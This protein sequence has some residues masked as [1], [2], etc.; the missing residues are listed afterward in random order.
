MGICAAL[1]LAACAEEEGRL[2]PQS[3]DRPWP[4]PS[5]SEVAARGGADQA[6]SI[7][8]HSLAPRA[9][10]EPEERAVDPTH[11]YGLADL[12]DLAQR[13]NPQTREAWE[14]ARAAAAQVGLAESEYLPQLSAEAI[15]GYQRTPLPIPATLVPQGYFTSDT[16]EVVP[17]LAVKWLLFDFGRRHAADVAAKENSFVANVA[18]T[19][20]HQRLAYTVSRDFFALGA[21]Y[22]KL[23]AAEKALQTARVDEEAAT[24]RRTTGVAT[25]VE[26]AQARRQ[27]AQAEFNVAR[28]QGAER[29]AQEALIASIGLMPTEKLQIAPLNY[30][31]LPVEPVQALDTLIENALSKRPDVLASLGKI[32][33]A[34]AHLDNARAD[35]NPSVSLVAQGY[36]NIG[37]L[38]SQ[39]GPYYGVDRP[40]WAVFLQ[41]AWPLFDG[42]QRHARES[43][44]RAQVGAAEEELNQARIV[45]AKE[46][47]DAYY[48][49][50]TS[51]AEHESAR[52]LVHAA[53]TAHDAELDA[54]KHGVGTYTDLI[55]GE[56]SLTQAQTALEDADADVRT[57]AAALA[58]ATGSIAVV[59]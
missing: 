4:I 37:S 38:S 10:S 39:G 5:Q 43:A 13:R 53:L 12:I 20:A 7:R 42:G 44:A 2:A 28:A 56:N 19:G 8:S 54:Y 30:E 1:L 23:D 27:T 57:A 11:R 24:A 46:V 29:N 9:G 26:L 15:A 25:V 21:A 36:Q 31:P 16:R 49:L 33:V 40:G 35:H 59:Q 32:R 41:F 22:G 6:D 47:T 18:F 48:A 51:L 50:R 52:A 58:F 55:N 34:A 17:T 45:A 3:A 14:Q